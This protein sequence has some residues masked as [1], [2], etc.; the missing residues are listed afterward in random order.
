MADLASKLDTLDSILSAHTYMAGNQFSLVDA[1]YMPLVHLLVGLGFRELVLERRHLKLWWE[2]V[3]QRKAWKE[4][5]EP[6]NK[7]YGL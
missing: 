1:F 7:V 3:T 5:V 2:M 4:A 6:F